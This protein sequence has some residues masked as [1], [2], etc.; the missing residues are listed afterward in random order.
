[1]RRLMGAISS[2][3]APLRSNA[4]A[5]SDLWIAVGL[6]VLLIVSWILPERLWPGFSRM[7]SPL[8]IRNVTP[9]PD[10]VVSRI[11]KMLRDGSGPTGGA[12]LRQLAAEHTLLVLQ[13]L[14]DYRPGGWNP[15]I[16]VDGTAHVTAALAQGRGA[17]LWIGF[18]YQADLV[19]K[20]AFR[21]AGFR[22]HHL[23][24]PSHGFSTTRFGRRFLNR[25]QTHI[26]DRYIDRRVLL[27]GNDP[28]PA[29]AA[30][31]AHLADNGVVS[32]S[33]RHDAKRPVKV[34]FGDGWLQLAPGAPVLSLKTGAPLLPAF[35]FRDAEGRLRLE[36][37]A[38]LAAPSGLPRPE[39]VVHLVE[40]YAEILRPFLRQHADQWV[41]W[42]HV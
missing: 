34:A 9:S 41:G 37:H 32:I 20:I 10:A 26:E 42:L 36:I 21:R 6:I 13:V 39:A 7:V 4:F 35:A 1:M 25:V 17:I 23:S 12:I 5:L 15:D 30:L 33:A 14:R 3:N 29:L 22:V 31:A 11:D 40:R 18:T 28:T 24:R 16:R 2:A 19:A 8:A 27:A 38:H